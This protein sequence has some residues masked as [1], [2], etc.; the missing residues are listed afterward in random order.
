[1]SCISA[2]FLLTIIVTAVIYYLMPMRFRWR[3]QLG[4]SQTLQK[5]GG[6]SSS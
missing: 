5:T 6:Y 1:M 2:G 4:I 3:L